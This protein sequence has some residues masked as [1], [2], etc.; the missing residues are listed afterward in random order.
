ML[1]LTITFSVLILLFINALYV[2]AEFSSISARP[3]RLNKMASEGNRSAS[4]ALEIIQNRIKLDSFIATCQVGITISSLA[5]GFYGQSIIAEAILPFLQGLGN[6]SAI[7]ARSVGITSTLIFLTLLQV[8]F[9]ELIPKNIGIQYPEK[10]SSLTAIPMRWSMIIFKPVIWLLNGSGRLFLRAISLE[11]S[12]EH[13]HI[14]SPEEIAILVD[15]SVKGGAII[16][17]EH[18]LLKN[19]LLKREAPVH[20]VMIPRA[21]M[22]TASIDSTVSELNTVLAESPYSRLPLYR[23]TIDN[24]V[25]FVH[26][27]DLLCLGQN[28][29]RKIMHSVPFV[30]ETLPVKNVF[31]LL[32]RKHFQVAIVMDEFG[33]TAGMVTLEDILE[34]LFG[35]IQ[36]EFDLTDRLI[37]VS[38]DNLLL[39][40]GETKIAELNNLIDIDLPTRTHNTIAG[41]VLNYLGHMANIGEKVEISGQLFRVRKVSGRSITTL[42]LELTAEQINLFREKSF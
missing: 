2:A 5:L 10:I 28:T 32:Q 33:G 23:E 31:S 30:P 17:E 8:T 19:T 7:T 1:W 3:S 27:K 38:G 24:I 42:S 35:D 13:S 40:P 4:F 20:T 37:R 9:G 34:E 14:H 26:L 29:P 12:P 39:I 18:F 41:L 36:D 6:L 22:L 21:R 11:L 15:E 25:G 16:P